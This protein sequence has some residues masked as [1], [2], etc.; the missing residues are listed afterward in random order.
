MEET[1]PIAIGTDYNSQMQRW[2]LHLLVG[3]F[4][5]EAQ[6]KLVGKKLAWHL[7]REFDVEEIE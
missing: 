2:D 5:T 6:A 1:N 3:N 7:E 4:A